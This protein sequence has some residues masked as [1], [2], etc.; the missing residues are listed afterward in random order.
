MVED[1]TGGDPQSDQ[2]WVRSSLRHLCD[3]L[4]VQGHCASPMTVKHLLEAQKY[5]LKA[6]VKRLT[7]PPHPDRD[8]QFEYIAATKSAFLEAGYPVISVD[9]KKKE[10]I[11][12]FKNAGRVWCQEAEPVNEHDFRQDAIG[13]GVPY[14]IYDVTHNLGD[15]YVGISLETP[16][17][18]VDAISFWW[19]SQGLDRYPDKDHI[20]ILADA[21]GSNGYRPKMWKKQLQVQLADGSG[22]T[23]TVCHYPTG[24]SKW[25][26]IEHRLFG[27]ISTNWVGQPLCTFETMLSYI[28]GTTTQTGLAVNAFL[29]EKEYEKGIKVSDEEMQALNLVRYETCPNWNYTIMPRL[30]PTN[31]LHS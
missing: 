12:N 26:P 20:L 9:A 31:P 23:V 8:R 22:L 2:K 24:A 29:V 30:N 1:Q 3:A 14:G 28:R 21:G 5:S 16:L 6:N 13:R 27:P 11:G 4:E 18:A 7:G 25:N 10:L 17:F 19:Q 15:V